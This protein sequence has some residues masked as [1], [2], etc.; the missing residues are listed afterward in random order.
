MKNRKMKKGMVMCFC[1]VMLIGIVSSLSVNLLQVK[2]QESLKTKNVNLNI[3]NSIAGMNDPTQGGNSGEW[4][5]SKVYFGVDTDSAHNLWRVLD[6]SEGLLL[7]DD[8]VTERRYDDGSEDW[9]A[10]ELK[11]WLNG[12]EYKNNTSIF[13]ILE[14]NAT[15]EITLLSLDD[16]TNTTY[17]F[18]N[19]M[20]NSNTRSTSGDNWWLRTPGKQ[21]VLATYV[22]CDGWI[23]SFGFNVDNAYGI[24]PVFN[25]NLDS[26]LF[27]SESE[28]SKASFKATQD[29]SDAISK[30]WDLT[31]KDGDTS[32]SATLPTR[33]IVGQ[34]IVVKVTAQGSESSYNQTS[35][36][37]VNED[38]TVAAY[39]KI[40]ENGTGDK[41]FTVPDTILAGSY[42]LYV[43]EE[44][45]NEGNLTDYASQVATENIIISKPGVT[46]NSTDCHMTK[47]SKSGAE[48]QT[49]LIGSMTQVVYTAD[50]GYYFPTDYSVAETK[51]I[52]VTRDSYTQ[53]TVS[54]TPTDDVTINLTAATQ[55]TTPSAPIGL[56]DGGG[57]ITGTTATMEYTST[58]DA[59]IWNVCTEGS[60]TLAAGIWY[61]R[62]KEIDT[63][64][65]SEAISV[66]VKEPKYSV[67]I[68]NG[69]GDGSYTQGT[70][71]TIKAA[72]APNGQEFTGWTSKDS[73][74]FGDASSENT[75]FKM[76]AKA[77]TVT[78]NY[79]NI[80][81]SEPTTPTEPV[82]PIVKAIQATGITL[83]KTSEDIKCGSTIKLTKTILPENTTDKGVTWSSSDTVIAT[84]NE[85]GIVTGTGIGSATITATSNSNYSVSATCVVNVSVGKVTGLTAKKNKT[86]YITLK[87][88]K[89]NNVDGYKIYR[90]NSAKK[91]Y[92]KIATIKKDS[93]TT[94]K[95]RKRKAATKYKYKVRA[96]VKIGK[97][98]K[99][100]KYSDILQTAT[101]SKKPVVTLKAGSKKVTLTWK[102]VSKVS[103]YEIY[104]STRK[105]SGY[106]KIKTLSSKKTKYT[107]KKLTKRKTYYFKIRTYKRVA[108]VKIYSSYSVV[109]KIKVK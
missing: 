43:F 103:G 50:E 84:V 55:K 18:T 83:D 52:K 14:Q 37:L 71:V 79:K 41:T 104:M 53:I 35:A 49:D 39:G 42:K 65:A 8:L 72:A 44:Q 106:S 4:E 19:S 26:I 101:K 27:T 75:F 66:D 30:T 12:N 33:G 48:S 36:L 25:L 6:A 78:A 57:K 28:M 16:A 81:T 82:T 89:Q 102:K 96:Y 87:W 24:R 13:S 77:V 100:G 3:S 64:N 45:V 85:N 1:T 17:G 51:G 60:T 63:A 11:S 31:L 97:K 21:P 2:A 20:D 15:S 93:T 38:N 98:T 7:A 9:S 108:G 92:V 59:E 5:G 10:S 94:Y 95:D 29:L 62:Y 22:N 91:K 54:G 90:Y 47:K 99:H 76:P 40:G 105:K 107:K 23:N 61:V 88:D 67:I 58:P 80:D 34:D 86:T 32:F 73:I 74:L 46:I 70:T 56:N 69:E 109:K 68:N